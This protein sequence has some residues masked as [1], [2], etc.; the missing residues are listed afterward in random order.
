MHTYTIVYSEF[1][2]DKKSYNMILKIVKTKKIFIGDTSTFNY[3]SHITQCKQH[4]RYSICALY[5][6]S[7]YITVSCESY[8][9]SSKMFRGNSLDVI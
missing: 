5:V 3:Y 8:Y 2:I 6:H 4:S 7:A 1:S 9:S